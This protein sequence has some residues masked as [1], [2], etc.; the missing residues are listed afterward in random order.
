[1]HDYRPESQSPNDRGQW[2]SSLGFVLAA[3]GSA[4][5]LGNI[6]RFPY[7]AG[8]NGG[9]AFV[10]LYLACIL[11][12]CL[13]YLFAELIV[14]R[15][16]H[17]NPV[18]A[19]KAI[20]PNTPWW[21]VG[22]IGVLTGVFIL[23]YYGVI[24]GWAFGYI[25]KGF[26]AADTTFGE[27]IANPTYVVPLF[28]L[29]LGF[30][31]VVVLGGV[32]AG[33]ERFSKILM[34]ILL[35]LMF[36]VIIRGL[37][38]PGAQAGLEFYLKPDFS[39]ITG[40]TVLAAL[41]QAF[42]SLSL[43]MGAMIT[44]GSYLPKT[45]NIRNAGA[46]VAVFDTG[47]ALLAGLMIYPA[48]FAT[49]KDPNEGPALVFDTLPAVFDAMPMGELIA[50]VFFILISI[51]ALTSTVSL[52]EVVTSYVVD[53]HRWSR[54]K[55]VFTVAA[56]TFV[57]GLPSALSQGAVPALG[58]E[59]FSILG[60]GDFLSLMDFIW[61]NISLALGALLLSV[62]VGWI[63]GRRGAEAELK[64]GG[65]N[66]PDGHVHVWW[67]FLKYVCPVVIFVVLL[68]VFGVFGDFVGG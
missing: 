27:F 1:M 4:I 60:Q 46:S 8:E 63:W 9:A 40:G 14:G 62:F 48:V 41:G 38:L 24:A 59:G 57:V 42:F 32:E 52:L 29:F 23:S 35:V 5:G 21:I 6:W 64:T 55:S 61:G 10:I 33:I 13:P 31:V 2:G 36:V 49:G 15:V 51:A 68:N 20:A 26:A 19:L 25:F 18:G 50:V 58:G 54:R 67:T 47:I 11:F 43:G 16:S 30:T 37:T 39:K 28:A 17:K 45:A 56:I 34:P 66:I 44:Y 12:I 3:A 65:E 53:E 7:V 22:G